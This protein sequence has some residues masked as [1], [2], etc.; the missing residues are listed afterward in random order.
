M[1]QL[2]VTILAA[3]LGLALAVAWAPRA[4]ACP[5][6]GGVRVAAGAAIAAAAHR[7]PDGNG[8]LPAVSMN[9]D[10]RC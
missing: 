10:P 8:P 6:G 9:S 4:Q 7:G 1:R 2:P 3:G 5:Q